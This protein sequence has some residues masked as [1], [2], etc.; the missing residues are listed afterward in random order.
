MV[1]VVEEK[2]MVDGGCG[3][4]KD[5]QRGFQEKREQLVEYEQQPQATAQRSALL[6]LL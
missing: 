5:K 3:V 2:A 1:V 6:P 4:A